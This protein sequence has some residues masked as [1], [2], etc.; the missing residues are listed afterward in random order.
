M[1]TTTRR[2]LLDLCML[3]CVTGLALV[4]PTHVAFVAVAENW[5]ADNRATLFAKPSPQ[6]PR[7]V[8][9]TI[10]E[11]T[12]A[13]F[14]YRFPVDRGFLASLL[15]HLA[16]AG[17][18]AVGIDILFDQP[19]EQAKDAAFREAAQRFPGPVVVGWTDRETGL[20]ERQWE[21]QTNY[22]EGVR[23]AYSNTLTDVSDSTI[24]RIFPGRMQEDGSFR[25][26]FVPAIAEA[27]G[28]LAP[29]EPTPIVYRLGP[30][31]TTPP[32][33]TFP[34]H[35]ALRLPKA[36]FKDKVVLIGADLPFEDRHRTPLAAGLGRKEGTLAGVAIH[37]HALAQL[38]DGTPPPRHSLLVEAV[39]AAALC[40]A[41]ALLGMARTKL[42]I[43]LLGAA[44][45][46]AAF[47][48]GDAL[49]FRYMSLELP[50]VAPTLAFVVMLL[51]SGYHAVHVREAE[52]R[53]IRDAFSRYVA[54]N[55]VARLQKDHS[56]L[57]LGGE[58]REVTVLFTDVES[59]TTMSET[60][61]AAHLV[62][63]LNDYLDGMVGC[64]HRHGGMVDKFIGDAVMAVFGAPEPCD[65]HAQRAVACALEMDAFASTF[66]NNTRARGVPFGR[67]RIG[68]H[69]GMAVV[70]NVGGSR[71]FDYTAIG[72]TVNT[73]SRMEGVNKYF[74]TS[75]CL[76]ASTAE[77][78]GLPLRPIGRIRVKG[79]Q[80][81]LSAFT[82]LAADQGALAVG[83]NQAYALLERGDEAA[84][85]A[86]AA[87]AAQFPDDALIRFHLGQLAEGPPTDLIVMKDK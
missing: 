6:H 69:T 51:L 48:A 7:L 74:G 64:V 8:L 33:R 54:P 80:E 79:R 83:Y 42:W 31:A 15:D 70:G 30:D 81:P 23:A 56:Q 35:M 1:R 84:R 37:A 29:S 86:F 17:A 61:D 72:D 87:L 4:L 13:A 78:C 47:W 3:A 9:L 46:L 21:F 75:I 62:A 12:L 10:T 66:V 67:T 20:T 28:H 40:A 41:A 63:V 26:G 14:P 27:L 55:L 44:L 39:M 24:R 32:I 49:A 85:A 11:D 71:R 22:L 45:A 36:W 76:S 43:Q 18:R 53:F 57:A 58:K 16:A 65:D 34:A 50:V 68:L 52:T 25:R 5:A 77:A 59:F 19:T 73:G 38:I 82:P 2:W 60:M